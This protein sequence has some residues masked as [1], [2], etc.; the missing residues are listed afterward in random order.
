[1]HDLS[2]HPSCFSVGIIANLHQGLEV[3]ALAVNAHG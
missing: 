3:A 1:M 2:A